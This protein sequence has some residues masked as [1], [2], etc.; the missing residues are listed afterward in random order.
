MPHI[1]SDAPF[2][3]QQRSWLDG[4][5]AGLNS[6]QFTDKKNNQAEQIQNKTTMNILFGTQTGN[7]EDLANDAANLAERY[8]N[9]CEKSCIRS[10][11][12]IVYHA[13]TSQIYAFPF[14]GSKRGSFKR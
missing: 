14:G 2:N 13:L 7:A 5:I 12:I 3:D 1:P 6:R 9:L 11:C 8:G 4:F 10:P